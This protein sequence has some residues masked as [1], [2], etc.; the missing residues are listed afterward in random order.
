MRKNPLQG[1]VRKPNL[2]DELSALL[3][4]YSYEHH[5]NT[6]DFILAAYVMACLDAFDVASNAREDWYGKHLAPGRQVA[7]A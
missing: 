1:A 7:D 6:P 4:K 2:Q 5:S 3:N